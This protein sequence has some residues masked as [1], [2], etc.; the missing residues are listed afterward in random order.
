MIEKKLYQCEFCNTQYAD[1]TVCE[2]CEKSHI[3][4]LSIGESRYK[5]KKCDSSGY[6][7]TLTVRMS[8][9]E[10]IVYKR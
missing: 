4:P 8:D 2:E 1:K 7:V 6:P 10:E 9:G 3:L 5:S